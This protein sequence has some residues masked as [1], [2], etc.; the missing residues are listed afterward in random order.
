VHGETLFALKFTE[1]RNME[2]LDR[3]FLAKYD[4]RTDNVALLEPY[5]SDEFFFEAELRE[6]EQDLSTALAELAS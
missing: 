4:Q 6:I 3:V 5:D 1:G 2:W